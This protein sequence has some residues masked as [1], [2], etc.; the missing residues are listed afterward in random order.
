MKTAIAIALAVILIIVG[1]TLMPT[2]ADAETITQG[3]SNTRQYAT[4]N[5]TLVASKESYMASVQTLEDNKAL[6][7]ADGATY[8]FPFKSTT[9]ITN[10]NYDFHLADVVCSADTCNTKHHY[11]CTSSTHRAVDIGPNDGVGDIY[12]VCSGTVEEIHNVC[13]GLWIRDADGYLWGYLHMNNYSQDYQ[14]GDKI[15]KGDII[16]TMGGHDGS[17]PNGFATHLDIRVTDGSIN[18]KT[19]NP[20]SLGLWDFQGNKVVQY[21]VSVPLSNQ[22]YSPGTEPFY[23][24]YENFRNLSEYVF[25]PQDTSGTSNVVFKVDYSSGSPEVVTFV[26]DSNMWGYHW[27]GV[28]SDANPEYILPDVEVKQ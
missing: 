23:T 21:N 7:E 4:S 6:K 20:I 12:A 9:G 15:H 18:T 1:F 8:L 16:G 5:L 14:V 24:F 26:K 17:N 25:S 22:R 27:Y 3:F 19:L 11:Y 10:I 13:N 28:E 2:S